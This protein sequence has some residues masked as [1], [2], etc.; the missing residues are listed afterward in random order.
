MHI[1]SLKV[2]IQS[3]YCIK[4]LFLFLFLLAARAVGAKAWFSAYEAM[5]ETASGSRKPGF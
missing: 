3:W 2:S 1:Y 5:F 4:G